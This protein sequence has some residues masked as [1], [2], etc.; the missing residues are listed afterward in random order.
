MYIYIYAYI[1]TYIYIYIYNIFNYDISNDKPEVHSAIICGS[2]RRKLEHYKKSKKAAK[3]IAIAEFKP[4]NKSNCFC[5]TRET[6]DQYKLS[7]GVVEENISMHNQFSSYQ[8]TRG[9]TM[10]TVKAQAEMHG[11][12]VIT[13]DQSISANKLKTNENSSISIEKT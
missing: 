4:Y 11:F 12:H 1:Y 13:S 7:I 5:L 6:L 2:C 10:A 3:I 9:L 8:S